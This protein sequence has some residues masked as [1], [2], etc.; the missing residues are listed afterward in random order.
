MFYRSKKDLT[1]TI[2]IWLTIAIGLYVFIS[3]LWIKGFSDLLALLLMTPVMVLLVWIWFQTGYYVKKDILILQSGPLKEAIDIQRI[4]K[5]TKEK[6]ILVAATLSVTRLK[7]QY[8]QYGFTY[9]SPEQEVEFLQELLKQN[10]DIQID[11]RLLL[12]KTH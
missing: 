9:A 11:E 1:Y 4:R 10:P 12:S 7:I 8:G 6:N 3:S 5:I 2:L